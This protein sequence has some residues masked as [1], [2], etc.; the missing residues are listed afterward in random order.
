MTH[1]GKGASRHSIG[2]SPRVSIDGRWRAKDRR[3]QGHFLLLPHDPEY[4]RH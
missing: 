1:L 4:R 3:E 2:G